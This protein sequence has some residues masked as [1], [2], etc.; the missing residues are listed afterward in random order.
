MGAT[1][2]GLVASGI[3]VIVSG[4]VFHAALNAIGIRLRN[5]VS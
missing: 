2:I 5:L 3:G 4:G 1:M